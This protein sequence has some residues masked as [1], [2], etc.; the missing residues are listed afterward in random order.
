[1][2][3]VITRSRVRATV[4]K[5]SVNV[6]GTSSEAGSLTATGTVSIGNASRLYKLKAATQKVAAGKSATLKLRMSRRAFNALRRTYRRTGR[7]ARVAISLSSTDAAGNSSA[8]K[9]LRNRVRPAGQ[10]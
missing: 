9:R 7:K 4:N 10:R 1:M 6:T 5:R 3:P 2:K 8:T